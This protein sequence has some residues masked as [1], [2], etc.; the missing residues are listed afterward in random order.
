MPNQFVVWKPLKLKSDGI[1]ARHSAVI[2]VN[3]RTVNIVHLL[4]QPDP[5]N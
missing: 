2:I 1:L 3:G 5:Q 4:Q